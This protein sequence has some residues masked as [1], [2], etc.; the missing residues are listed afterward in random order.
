MNNYTKLELLKNELH[1]YIDVL[2]GY[3]GSIDSRK[4][5]KHL[6]IILSKVE[7]VKK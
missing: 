6:T 3:N 1:N 7:G 2:Q 5:G 4:V